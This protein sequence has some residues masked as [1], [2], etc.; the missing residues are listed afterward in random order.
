MTS[1]EIPLVAGNQTFTVSLGEIE[2]RMRLV[3]RD[4]IDGGWVLD[5]SDEEGTAI[6]LGLPLV[7]G[8]DLLAQHR[9]LGI[10]GGGALWCIST[11]DADA[12]PTWDNL[13]DLSHLMWTPDA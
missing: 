4:A 6:L 2:Y 11:G 9:H 12:V 13:G 3:Y 7:T 8:A 5:I 10:G 1:Y